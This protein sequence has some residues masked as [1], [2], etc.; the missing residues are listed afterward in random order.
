MSVS[1]TIKPQE[2]FYHYVNQEWLNTNEIPPG[3]SRWSRFNELSDKTLD[4]LKVILPNIKDNRLSK[5]IS[6]FE[7]YD[8]EKERV[9]INSLIEEI[10]ATSS[11]E[12]LLELYQR[13][14]QLFGLRFLYC[15]GVESDMKNSKHNVLYL[16]PSGLSLPGR[17]YYLEEQ[18]EDKRTAYVEFVD[19]LSAFH[20]LTISGT[21]IL[22]LETELAKLHLK[23]DEK[24]N[25]DNVYFVKTE[26]DIRN[27][28]VP[29]DTYFKTVGKR[30][31]NP[32]D[33][34]VCTNEKYFDGF[35]QKNEFKDLKNYLKFKTIISFSKPS[36]GELYNLIYEFYGKMLSGQKEKLPQWKRTINLINGTL[37]ELLSKEYIGKHFSE[38]AKHEVSEMISY[39]KDVLREMIEKNTWMEPSTKSKAL[40]KLE[41]INWKIGYPNKWKDFSTLKFDDC[42]SLSECLSRVCEWWFYDEAKELYQ[43]TDLEKWEML[44]HQVNAYYHPLLNEIVFPAAILQE[45]FFSLERGMPENYGGIGVVIA[46]EITHGFDDQGKRFDAEGN[47]NNWW[48]ED[49]EKRFLCEAEKL[50]KQFDNLELYD[51]KL[52]GKLT[53]GEN[54]ADLG[55]V[56]ISLVALTNKLGSITVEES[57]KFF[58]SFACIWA[59][60][61]SPE[62]GQKLIKIDPHSP[63]QFRVN[64][65]L[66][67][68]D[69]FHKIYDIKEE[70]KM[71]MKYENRCQIWSL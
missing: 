21:S 57:K 31:S 52:N 43:A 68:L 66:P 37:G 53:L 30:P 6:L 70:N 58:E 59:N 1:T 24:R 20:K 64:S 11:I 4:Q 45:P 32:E 47:L 44:A 26:N 8:V 18:F 41:N 71:F 29:L 38:K 69:E 2:S 56:R 39:F 35:I 36:Q 14:L 55:G 54:L 19:K 63:G 61:C 49:D 5:L 27:Y 16:E 13:K 51:T 62:E 33:K 7:K 46:H 48:T 28:G 25:P 40:E 3:Y 50:E 60:L 10:D 23:P 17:D 22:E 9:F 42:N 15:F 67:H 12:S 65:I 34:L